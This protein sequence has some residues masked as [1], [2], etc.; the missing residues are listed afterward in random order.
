MVPDW[1]D[2][3]GCRFARIEALRFARQHLADWRKEHFG[4][5]RRMARH[6]LAYAAECRRQ[7]RARHN[8]RKAA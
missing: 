5:Q 7:E 6:S 2:S 8:Q 4:F 3:E 1:L